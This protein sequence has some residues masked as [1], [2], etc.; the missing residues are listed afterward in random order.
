MAGP[1]G[2]PAGWWNGAADTDKPVAGARAAAAGQAAPMGSGMYGMPAG[3]ASQNRCATDRGV[4]EADRSIVLGEFGDAVPVLT[5]DG[6]VYAD[7]QG[8]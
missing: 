3:A 2:L 6:V 5:D 4:A 1:V 8:V 7:G